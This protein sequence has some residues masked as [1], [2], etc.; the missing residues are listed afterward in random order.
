MRAY[1]LPSHR[2]HGHAAILHEWTYESTR[3]Q[4]TQRARRQA[5]GRTRHATPPTPGLSVSARLVPG[6]RARALLSVALHPSRT[7][8]SPGSPAARARPHR[9]RQAAAQVKVQRE[10]RA[11]VIVR[12]RLGWRRR[13]RR[14]SAGAHT[15]PRSTC[16]ACHRRLGGAATRASGRRGSGPLAF[17]ITIFFTTCEIE[18]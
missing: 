15:R 17:F 4:L 14:Q 5:G 1:S 6:A 12:P 10:A 3:E 2:M 9:L 7:V 18:R 8:H 13:R 16:G 11:C